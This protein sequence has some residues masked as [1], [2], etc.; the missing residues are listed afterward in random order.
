VAAAVVGCWQRGD[1]RGLSFPLQPWGN[2]RALVSPAMTLAARSC[3]SGWGG[4]SPTHGGAGYTPPA[5]AA[6]ASGKVLLRRQV[7]LVD[8]HTRQLQHVRAR[9]Q[10]ASL[11]H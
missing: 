5:A 2:P 7:G 4:W 6:R 10:P 11:G 9:H 1:F 3:A 8:P